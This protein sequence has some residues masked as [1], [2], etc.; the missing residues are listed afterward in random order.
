VEY[1]RKEWAALSTLKGIQWANK[2][3]DLGTYPLFCRSKSCG[4]EIINALFEGYCVSCALARG[5]HARVLYLYPMKTILS[6]LRELLGEEDE[7]LAELKKL[8]QVVQGMP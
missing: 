6:R 7:G 4:R 5:A 3:G 2:P 1:Y 8:G